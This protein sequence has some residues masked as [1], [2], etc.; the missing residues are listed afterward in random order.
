M[1]STICEEI[2]SRNKR[3]VVVL[4]RTEDES[5][6]H[7]SVTMVCSRKTSA[8]S[9]GE[10]EEGNVA[11]MLESN[12]GASEATRT[13]IDY[14]VDV[15]SATGVSRAQIAEATGLETRLARLRGAGSASLSRIISSLQPFLG[16]CRALMK[17]ANIH[18]FNIRPA[19]TLKQRQ[20]P[21]SSSLL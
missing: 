5:C 9:T 8:R 1:R 18:H 12:A 20:S 7:N 3:Y 14:V 13:G 19:T 6:I 16:C 17:A 4:S 21:D 10:R 11:Q 15:E 2:E